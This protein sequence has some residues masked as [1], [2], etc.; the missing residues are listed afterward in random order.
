MPSRDSQTTRVLTI[1]NDVSQLSS[2]ANLLI[3]A[4]YSV[5]LEVN[6]ERALR[7]MRIHPYHL[8][9]LS[10]KLSHNEQIGI[11]AQLRQVRSDQRVLLLSDREDDAD[12]LLESVA[13]SLRHD[14]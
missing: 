6:L 14:R 9:I 4:G 13:S 7:R 8:V 11:R 12:G 2:R 5:D 1:G 10:G 3:H